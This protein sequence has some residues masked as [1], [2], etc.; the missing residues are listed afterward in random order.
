MASP[1]QPPAVESKR[2]SDNAIQLTH[3]QRQTA[4]PATAEQRLEQSS[5]SCPSFLVKSPPSTQTSKGCVWRRQETRQALTDK[6][7]VLVRFLHCK[8]RRS[9]C[10]RR[11]IHQDHHL[12]RTMSPPEKAKGIIQLPS[13]PALQLS[14][15]PAHRDV[16][17]TNN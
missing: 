10:S 4:E 13:S 15:S 16:M 8:S 17:I 1:L 12:S 5:R 6:L 11:N 2:N 7:R 14:S 3:Q 9:S